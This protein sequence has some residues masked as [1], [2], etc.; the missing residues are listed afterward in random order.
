MTQTIDIEQMRSRLLT[1]DDARGRLEQ[2]EHLGQYEFQ[3]DGSNSV[4]FDFPDT[5][6]VGLEHQDDLFVTQASVNLDGFTRHLTKEAALKAFAEAGWPKALAMKTPGKMAADHV[7]YWYNGHMDKGLKLLASDQAALGFTRDTIQPF[8][9]IEILNRVLDAI[10]D[11]Y[12]SN[13]VLVDYKFHHDLKST[14]MRLIVPSSV[15]H[16]ASARCEQATDDPW[17]VGIDIR[18]SVT[19]A[20]SLELKGYLFA[21]WCTNGATSTHASSGKYRRKPTVDSTDAYDWARHVVDEVLGGLEGELDQVES[22]PNI[23][24][25]GELN[26]TLAGVFDR[27]K[28]PQRAREDVIANLVESDDLTAYGLMNAITQAAN[29]DEMS[30]A[31]VSA[32]LTAGGNVAHVMGDRCPT[33]HKF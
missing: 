11:R 18:N 27:F 6:N 13:D 14:H 33:C 7:N 25:D 4:N 20:E 16:I 8:S 10:Q 2:T 28:V 24:L 30:P 21:W 1:L 31:A 23:P 15:R 29:D 12:S 26:A 5:W 19:G 3:T 32:L 9:N 17:S 22:L